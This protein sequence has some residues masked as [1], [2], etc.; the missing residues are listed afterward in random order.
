[1]SQRVSKRLITGDAYADSAIDGIYRGGNVFLTFVGMEY[2]SAIAVFTIYG[3]VGILGQ[4][5]RL[6]VGSTIAAATVLTAVSGTTAAAAP[7]TLTASQSIIAEDLNMELVYA[8]K[9]RYVPL[10]LRLY[11]YSSTGIKWFSQT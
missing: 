4:V 6:D 11:P 5:G 8:S 10:T 1:M 2:A 9:E 7:A 3:A